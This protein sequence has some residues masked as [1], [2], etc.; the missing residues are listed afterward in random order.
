ML[1][2]SDVYMLMRWTYNVENWDTQ[3]LGSEV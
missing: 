1:K 3:S 2:V